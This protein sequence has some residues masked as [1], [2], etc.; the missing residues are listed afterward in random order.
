M[1]DQLNADLNDI[2]ARITDQRDR[3]LE[4]RRYL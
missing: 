1:S 3:L 4:L 2:R